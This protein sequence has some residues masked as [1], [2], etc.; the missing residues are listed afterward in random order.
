MTLTAGE[1]VVLVGTSD[2]QEFKGWF[3]FFFLT[4]LLQYQQEQKQKKLYRGFVG[5]MLLNTKR[6][7]T[8]LKC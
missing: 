1:S 3:S 7:V 2:E 4:K 6:R 8:Y 5:E